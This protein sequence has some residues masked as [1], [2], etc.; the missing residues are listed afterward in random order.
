MRKIIS[1]ILIFVS[2]IV[3]MASYCDAED[4]NQEEFAR[5]I[6]DENK[7]SRPKELK[8][9]YG[10]FKKIVSQK[11]IFEN[12][13]VAWSFFDDNNEK[14]LIGSSGA[15]FCGSTMKRDLLLKYGYDII[16][17]GGIFDE[18]VV[19]LLKL[20][21]EKKYKTIVVFGGVNDLNVRAAFKLKDIDLL[22]CE[23]LIKLINEAKSHLIDENLNVYY[24]NVKP[25]TLYR[26]S[27]DEQLVE[28]FNDMV[29]EVNDNIESFGF[30]SYDFPQETIEE[31]SEH[32]VH[33]NNV[34]VYEMLFNSVD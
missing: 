14:L 9:T 26:D 7:S 31:Y 30:K 12:V 34:V 28:R 11:G 25:M 21:G 16:G 23:T 20:L 5:T 1:I 2:S 3:L 29:K 27:N 6:I 15:V 18:E 24:I 22:Y 8:E 4:F 19:D 32:Y 33:Y 13:A 10:A 17:F